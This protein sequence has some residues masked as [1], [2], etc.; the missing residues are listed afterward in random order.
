MDWKTD[1]VFKGLIEKGKQSG[2][3]TYDEVNQALPEGVSDGDRLAELLHQLEENGINIIDESD[4]DDGSTRETAQAD[5]LIAEAEATT[6]D[7]D[8]DGR[9]IDDPVRMYLTQMGQHPPAGPP[10]G[11][12]D[13]R[14]RSKIEV[15]R[16]P[17]P[18][19]GVSNAIMPS[20]MWPTR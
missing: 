4:G 17:V 9:H 15:T 5:E 1:E 7:T 3:L 2:S 8:G 11:K 16:K 12:R 20:A 14:S 10:S 13:Q 6:G 19:Q 18:P